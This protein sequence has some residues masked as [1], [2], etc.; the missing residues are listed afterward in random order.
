MKTPSST[1]G[2]F[3][4]GPSGGKLRPWC[5]HCHKFLKSETAA[6]DCT[7]VDFRAARAAGAA[8]ASQGR[9]RIRLTEKNRALLSKVF[10]GA[11]LGEY[12]LKVLSKVQKL[13]KQKTVSGKKIGK[14][15]KAVKDGVPASAMKRGNSLKKRFL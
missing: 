10:E 12:L 1:P 11:A 9:R 7:P 6:H 4:V 14:V 15:L 8:K 5:A 2:V 3:L 13:S